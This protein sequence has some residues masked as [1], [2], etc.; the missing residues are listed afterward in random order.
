MLLI[1]EL[2]SFTAPDV[3]NPPA[4][5]DGRKNIFSIKKFD[6]GESESKE[7]L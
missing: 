5:Y 7:V 4:A 3:F 2:Q 6:F 1:Q